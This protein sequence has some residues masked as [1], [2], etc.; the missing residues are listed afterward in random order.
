L[1]CAQGA[2]TYAYSRPKNVQI[3]FWLLL[4]CRRRVAA[5][6]FCPLSATFKR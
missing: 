5:L 2:E 6:S 1:G 3:R 4:T